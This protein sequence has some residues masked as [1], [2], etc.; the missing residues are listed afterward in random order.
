MMILMKAI[1][2]ILIVLRVARGRAWTAKTVQEEQLSKIKFGSSN[3]KSD[4]STTRA[5]GS[6]NSNEVLSM[7]AFK[8]GQ[9][10]S[11]GL[12]SDV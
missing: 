8:P 11:I 3:Y 12:T 7:M 4:G 6:N 1:S 5:N 2:P 10:E 9:K